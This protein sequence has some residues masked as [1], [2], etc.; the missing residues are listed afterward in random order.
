MPLITLGASSLFFRG[1]TDTVAGFVLLYSGPTAVAGFIWVS[2]LGGDPALCL[3]LILID[4][5][6]SPLVTPWTM[7]S[8]WE[9]EQP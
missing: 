5:L 4:S 1:D 9:P 3:T 8:S 2:I 6:L 7:R